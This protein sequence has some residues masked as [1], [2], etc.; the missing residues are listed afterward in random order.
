MCKICEHNEAL[1]SSD[2]ILC[3]DF[4]QQLSEPA[5]RY[6]RLLDRVTVKGSKEPLELYTFDVVSIPRAFGNFRDVTDD[7][8]LENSLDEGSQHGPQ[9]KFNTQG[10][11]QV[12][13]L[14]LS[15]TSPEK[16]LDSCGLFKR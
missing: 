5:Q 14:A 7:L 15:Y 16:F 1:T 6:L 12:L 4:A 9:A 13:S 3:R 8:D 10:S 2:E 11:P